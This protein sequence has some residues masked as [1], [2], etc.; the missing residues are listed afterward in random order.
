M[1]FRDAK[2]RPALGDSGRL[3]AWG[4]AFVAGLLAGAGPFMLLYAPFANSYRRFRSGSY[5]PLNGTWAWDNRTVMVRLLAGPSGNRLEFRLPGADVN[6]YH[7]L[8]AA[9]ASGLDGVE[10]GLAPPPP[11]E[12]DA[13]GLAPDPLP[14]DLT[15][16]L[17]AFR[18]SDVARRAFGAPVH[19]H[20]LGLASREREAARLAITDWDFL[21]GFEFA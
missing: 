10:R 3:S 7:A 18:D 12:G 2:G 5:V 6:P 8:A 17:A 15:E 16:A 4:E 21:R 13:S 14:S 11:V 20:L 1:S 9:I 19:A